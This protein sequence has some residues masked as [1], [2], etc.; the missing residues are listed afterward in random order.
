[1]NFEQW[2]SQR[3]KVD[4]LC[5]YFHGDSNNFIPGIG[6]YIYPGDLYIEQVTVEY[7]E[8]KGTGKAYHVDISSSRSIMCSALV[9]LERLLFEYWRAEVYEPDPLQRPPAYMMPVFNRFRLVWSGIRGC[10]IAKVLDRL[11]SGT[12]VAYSDL[13]KAHQAKDELAQ[14]FDTV[15]GDGHVVYGT[16]TL[17]DVATESIVSC[18]LIS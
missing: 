1:M 17:V 9:E 7:P 12:V 10:P 16:L 5:E 8:T 3:R 14:L 15:I 4:C 13:Y 6:G 11:A 18:Q 2:S